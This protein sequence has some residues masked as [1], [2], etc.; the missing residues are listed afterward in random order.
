M[1][2]FTTNRR[3]VAPS[4]LMCV[5]PDD[6]ASVSTTVR[7]VSNSVRL[8][9][10]I[11]S[12]IVRRK[13][14]LIARRTVHHCASLQ[15][16]RVQAAGRGSR[17]R[18]GDA[19]L[20]LGAHAAAVLSVPCLDTVTAGRRG[21]GEDRRAV[22]HRGGDPRSPR[23][24]PEASQAGTKSPHCGGLTCLVAGACRAC[25]GRLGSGGCHPLCV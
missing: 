3:S 17:G 7:S 24:A 11:F 20:L 1:P 8:W 14:P 12:R 21:A 15:L 23:R 13:R 5:E 25:L 22:C 19:G 2:V 18:F 16:C 10:P 6:L 4:Q 9:S